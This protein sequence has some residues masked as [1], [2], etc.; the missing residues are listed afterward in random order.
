M[1]KLYSL[2]IFLFIGHFS[3]SANK[4]F[5]SGFTATND[6]MLVM[7]GCSSDLKD[8]LSLVYQSVEEIGD[9]DIIHF[10]KA[11]NV[12]F[13]EVKNS[14]VQ[15]VELYMEALNKRLAK[16]SCT[17]LLKQGNAVQILKEMCLPKDANNPKLKYY[18]NSN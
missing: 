5:Q 9:S 4:S 13:I 7:I 8:D 10:N 2:L 11:N 6:S 15:N 12:F 3:I 18:L 14:Y 17:G 16:N 1:N